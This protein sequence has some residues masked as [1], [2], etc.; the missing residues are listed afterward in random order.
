MN[1]MGGEA[2]QFALSGGTT[3]KPFVIGHWRMD[4]TR[5]LPEDNVPL[6]GLIMMARIPRRTAA[7][8]I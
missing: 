4:M 1:D 8:L 2:L 3:M 7:G 6:T 5:M